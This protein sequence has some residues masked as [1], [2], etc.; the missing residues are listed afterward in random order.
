MKDLQGAKEVLLLEKKLN[1]GNAELDDGSSDREQK[2]RCLEIQKKD[3]E[4][5]MEIGG[6]WRA[7]MYLQN[8][9]IDWDLDVDL[10]P[11]DDQ[12]KKIL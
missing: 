7:A 2:I 11:K 9:D 10:W 1:A 8:G 5:A 6:G 3:L 4:K 12:V